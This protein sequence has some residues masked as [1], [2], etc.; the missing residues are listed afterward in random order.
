MTIGHVISFFNSIFIFKTRVQNMRNSLELSNPSKR[1]VKN[2]WKI[3]DDD[4]DSLK[5]SPNMFLF[6]IFPN[7]GSYMLLDA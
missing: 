5:S 4:I 1:F 7:K 3:L 2:W 6:N